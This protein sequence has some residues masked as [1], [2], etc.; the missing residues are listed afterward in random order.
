MELPIGRVILLFFFGNGCHESS[1]SFKRLS[2]CDRC[3]ALNCVDI[4]WSVKA[5]LPVA[6]NAS[7][8]SSAYTRKQDSQTNA[9]CFSNGIEGDR[10]G[11][12]GDVEPSSIA[13]ISETSCPCGVVHRTT[14]RALPTQ[15]IYDSA[16]KKCG[17]TKT[18]YRANLS[19]G[20]LYKKSG[21]RLWRS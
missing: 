4:V 14:T 15:T 8:A 13:Y 16:P 5:C 19:N 6:R 18:T 9:V 2:V 21:S 10:Y 12:E 17:R 1:F 7:D 20:T 11:N 3:M